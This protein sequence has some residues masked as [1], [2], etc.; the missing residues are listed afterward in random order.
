MTKSIT[1][2]WFIKQLSSFFF[3]YLDPI[4]EARFLHHREKCSECKNLMV[5]HFVEKTEEEG[6]GW[7]AL[8]ENHKPQCLSDTTINEY[9]EGKLTDDEKKMVRDHIEECFPCQDMVN[10]YIEYLEKK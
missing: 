10:G 4:E 7:I 5:G 1:C 8:Q 9:G 3:G 6:F 2:E